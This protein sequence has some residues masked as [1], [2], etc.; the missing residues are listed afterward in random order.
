M[1]KIKKKNQRIAGESIV[2][3]KLRIKRLRKNLVC[4]GPV[5]TAGEIRG[6]RCIHYAFQ[7]TTTQRSTEGT[8][9]PTHRD[10]PRHTQLHVGM[11]HKEEAS[12]QPMCKNQLTWDT[13]TGRTSRFFCFFFY[14]YSLDWPFFAAGSLGVCY[15]TWHVTAV[16]DQWQCPLKNLR[17]SPNWTEASNLQQS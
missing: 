11:E 15:W 16:D 2:D 4:K 7:W 6:W 5:S 9:P 13:S 3:T 8:H 14:C 10:T 1:L 17:H 12:F